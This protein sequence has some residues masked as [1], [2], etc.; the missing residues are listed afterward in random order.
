MSSRNKVPLQGTLGV[1]FKRNNK[2]QA[3]GT[4]INYLMGLEGKSAIVGG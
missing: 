2:V 4:H 3:I 1:S